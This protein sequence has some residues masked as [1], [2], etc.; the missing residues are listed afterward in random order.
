MVSSSRNVTTL[1]IRHVN[2][3][4]FTKLKLKFGLVLN[5]VTSTLNIMKIRSSVDEMSKTAVHKEA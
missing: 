2:I 4:Y 5:S 3:A 1:S